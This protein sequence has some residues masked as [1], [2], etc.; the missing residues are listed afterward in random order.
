MDFKKYCKGISPSA[1]ILVGSVIIAL[2]V[3]IAGGTIPLPFIK[4][5]KTDVVINPT[6][7]AVAPTQTPQGPP[8]VT[9]KASGIKTFLEK[10][11]AQICADNGKPVIYLFS[12]T[13]CPHCQ[14]IAETFDKV[15][16]EYISTGKIKAYHWELDTNDD[17]LT[18]E[19]ET[20]IPDN[21]MVVYSEFNP[22]NSIPTFVFGCKYFRVGNGYEGQQDLSLEENE[23]RAVI[24]DLIK[25]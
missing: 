7:S 22:R 4:G 25:S 17:V 8:F 1:A 12:T 3:L 24:E 5:A 23:L 20:K 2:A 14:W 16:K 21:D 6:P 9:P 19:K 13:S 11:D 15:V 10:K 18:A